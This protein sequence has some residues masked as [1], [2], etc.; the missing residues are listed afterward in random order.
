MMKNRSGPSPKT[1]PSPGDREPSASESSSDVTLDAPSSGRTENRLA[2]IG[3]NIAGLRSELAKL[4]SE[5]A[6]EKRGR[7]SRP[8][9]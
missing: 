6:S 7:Q 9:A 3:K 5:Q 4:A 2:S 1:A 8:P